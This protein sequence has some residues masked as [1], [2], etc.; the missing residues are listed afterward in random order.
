[1]GP[2]GQGTPVPGPK[3]RR[4]GPAG[5]SFPLR[6]G[7]HSSGP[8]QTWRPPGCPALASRA[9]PAGPPGLALCPAAR[10]RASQVAQGAGD[11]CSAGPLWGQADGG[12]V[13]RP[14]WDS[15]VT[16]GPPDS[17]KAQQRGAHGSAEE[18]RLM[19]VLHHVC[20]PPL[21]PQPLPPPFAEGKRP[22]QNGARNKSKTKTQWPGQCP[23][24]LRPARWL[25]RLGPTLAGWCGA[26]RVLRL[27]G[28]E[29][30]PLGSG[31]S[32]VVPERPTVGQGRLCL[33]L[34]LVGEPWRSGSEAAYR[35]LY[36]SLSVCD[37]NTFSSVSVHPEE[38]SLSN[39][40]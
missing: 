32:H 40:L 24:S 30:G 5:C 28:A 10:L 3:A 38:I 26:F 29:P 31:P 34:D 15:H 36:Q 20:Q 37:R 17:G 1:M 19:A 13:A 39:H 11:R 14:A 16:P 23:S 12:P 8:A 9:R 2:G 33:F 4:P 25:P 22:R 35:C 18:F 6:A 27:L 21:P 7:F